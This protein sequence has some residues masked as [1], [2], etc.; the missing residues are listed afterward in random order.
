MRPLEHL[1]ESEM[2]GVRFGD[3]IGWVTMIFLMKEKGDTGNFCCPAY[4]PE[5]ERLLSVKKGSQSYQHSR[6]TLH[7]LSLANCHVGIHKFVKVDQF[8]LKE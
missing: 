8:F 6:L 7:M 3:G 2:I 5:T 4:F 1:N